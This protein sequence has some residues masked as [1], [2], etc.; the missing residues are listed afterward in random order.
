MTRLTRRVFRLRINQTH[1]G[2]SFFLYTV[3]NFVFPG[4]PPCCALGTPTR[5]RVHGA[6][7]TCFRVSLNQN[8]SN[9]IWSNIPL[10]NGAKTGRFGTDPGSVSYVCRTTYIETNTFRSAVEI[11][12]MST[13]S[14]LISQK[15]YANSPG[16]DLDNVWEHYKTL[17][18]LP[19]S[20]GSIKFIFDVRNTVNNN[21]S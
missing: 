14:T 13:R 19:E 12:W 15:T 8:Q 9:G 7:R 18:N 20:F 2:S 3:R 17:K 6:T 4:T 10:E 21:S 5:P 11:V 1:S 16:P